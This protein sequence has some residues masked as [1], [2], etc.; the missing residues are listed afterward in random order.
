MI[1]SMPD[2][3]AQCTS[4]NLL[5]LGQVTVY[6]SHYCRKAI[7][8]YCQVEGKTIRTNVLMEF[9]RRIECNS[10]A[11]RTLVEASMKN[12][13]KPYLKLPI[14]LLIRSCLIDSILGLY[15]S[16]LDEDATNEIIND[17]N[18][19]YVKAMPDRYE[20]YSDRCATT[21]F[22]D[23]LLKHMY[24]LQ[25]EDNYPNYIDWGSYH[26]DDSSRKG[27]FKIKANSRLTISKAYRCLKDDVRYSKLSKK[28]YAYYREYSQYE[29]F[30]VFSR[31]SYS[32]PYDE[33]MPS[34]AKSFEYIAMAVE[35]VGVNMRL[36][37]PM[38]EHLNK[39]YT[40]IVEML[41]EVK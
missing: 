34:M 17:F 12:A 21:N 31:D 41:N 9:I 40:G 30:S 25:I 32:S 20:V 39:A 1:I 19:D 35:C 10:S 18:Q 27:F 33:D 7:L 8:E 38:T 28:L 3:I 37:E 26:M 6:I 5:Q 23:E 2:N 11:I 24:G 13:S 15:L 14:G 22:S 36:S 4:L 16:A 29:H